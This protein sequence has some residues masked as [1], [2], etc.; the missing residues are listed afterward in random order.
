MESRTWAGSQE[1]LMTTMNYSC[2]DKEEAR[3]SRR[4]VCKL[5][6]LSVADSTP[7]LT[8]AM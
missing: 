8:W 2:E 3:Y 4:I 6:P 5:N 7:P 1:L